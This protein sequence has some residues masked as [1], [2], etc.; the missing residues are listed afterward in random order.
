[1]VMDSVGHNERIALTHDEIVM[2]FVASCVEDIAE[3]LDVG[4][5]E[6]YDRMNAVGLIEKYIIPHYDVLHTESRDNVTQ[7]VLETLLRWEGMQ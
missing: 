7:G 6:V 5:L 2:G 3:R 1:M 4:Y